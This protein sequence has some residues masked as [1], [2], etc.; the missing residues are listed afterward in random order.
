MNALILV[1]AMVGY[2][3][4]TNQ[5]ALEAAKVKLAASGKVE[6][7][8]RSQ[9]SKC[10]GTGKITAGDTVTI[11]QRDC[12]ACYDDGKKK[13]TGSGTVP[14]PPAEVKPKAATPKQAERARTKPRAAFFTADWCGRC[15]AM[16]NEQ[17]SALRQQGWTIG[18]SSCDI[19]VIDFDAR[20]D[21]V[22]KYAVGSV[23]ALVLLWGDREIENARLTG[24]QTSAAVKTL[25]TTRI[26]PQSLRLWCRKYTGGLA[27]T[28][29][30]SQFA[31]L[32]SPASDESHLGGHFEPW[33]LRGLS[34]SELTKIHG[35]QHNGALTPFG[36]LK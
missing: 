11:V 28:Q 27:Y 9:C 10:K 21:L 24:Y 16:D 19:E 17:F 13:A 34:E 12:D 2:G 36:A 25:F 30:M 7:V 32:T 22:A 18:D 14:A 8:P 1:L 20:P 5:I 23:P 26:G 4:F 6:L 29:G 33:Q 15:K 35:G 3:D 31:H